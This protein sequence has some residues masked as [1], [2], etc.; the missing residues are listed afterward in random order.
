M[1][2]K[3]KLKIGFIGAQGTGKT[4][5]AYDLVASLKKLGY[6]ATVEDEV[7]RKCPLDINEEATDE[8]Q[9]WILG[10]T[11]CTE[12]EQE[13]QKASNILVCDRTLLDQHCYLYRRNPVLAKQ[14]DEF[15]KN[16]VLNRYDIIF[17]MSPKKSYLIDD[18]VRSVNKDFQQQIKDI[19]ESYIDDWNIPVIES[20]KPL[21]EVIKL[22]EEDK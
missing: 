18:G 3:K 17:Y 22:I 4:T 11:L 12:M 5:A 21:I 1:N 16:Y 14:L 19:M 2:Y 10:K 13:Q 15:V 20:N 9:L 8:A 7:A 6:N